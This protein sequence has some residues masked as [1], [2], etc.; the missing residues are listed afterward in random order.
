MHAVHPLIYH[1]E[2]SLPCACHISIHRSL[3]Y[4]RRSDR[5]WTASTSEVLSGLTSSFTELHFDDFWLPQHFPLQIQSHQQFPS[6]FQTFSW[7]PQSLKTIFLSSLSSMQLWCAYIW[8]NCVCRAL[9][10]LLHIIH[11][12]ALFFYKCLRNVASSNFS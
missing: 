1:I 10:R 11:S 6:I 12:L 2:A 8:S 9:Y 3:S 5:N 7:A 4:N